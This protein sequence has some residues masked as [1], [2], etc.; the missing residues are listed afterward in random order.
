MYVY[1][2]F[3]LEGTNKEYCIKHTNIQESDKSS[4]P[5]TIAGISQSYL[6]YLSVQSQFQEFPNSVNLSFLFSFQTTLFSLLNKFPND[7]NLIFQFSFLTTYVQF[8]NDLCLLFLFIFQ[9]TLFCFLNKFINVVDLVFRFS[10]PS[11]LIQFSN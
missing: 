10:F 4:I 11:A 9:T 1:I 3:F 7:V 2:N 8:P 5:S 6:R